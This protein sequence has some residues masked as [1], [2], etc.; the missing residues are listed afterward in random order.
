MEMWRN[1][2][3]VAGCQM[4]NRGQSHD[5]SGQLRLRLER[6]VIALKPDVVVLEIGV[7]DLKSIGALPDQEQ[8]IIDRLKANRNAIIDRL[9]AAGINVIVCTIFPFGD[10]TLARR[11][12]WSDRTLAARDEINREVRQLNR[13]R[14]TVFDADPIFL[15]DGRMKGEYQ[16]DELHLNETGYS[17][18]NQALAPVIESIVRKP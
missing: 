13:P 16:L 17:A 8:I 3:L 4:V 6:D 10:L 7:N 11:P 1:L 5:T 14:L 9:T 18:L 2:P 15:V 12:V